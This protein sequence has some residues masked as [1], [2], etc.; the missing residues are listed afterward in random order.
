MVTE[1]SQEGAGRFY[2]V[3]NGVTRPERLS[4]HEA[5]RDAQSYGERGYR[6]AVRKTRDGKPD[7][8]VLRWAGGK[9]VT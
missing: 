7:L 5:L 1:E 3:V 2:L 6:V 9:K 4:Q 8:T